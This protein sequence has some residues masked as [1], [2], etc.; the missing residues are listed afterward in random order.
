MGD[1]TEDKEKPQAAETSGGGAEVSAGDESAS[2]GGGAPTTMGKMVIPDLTP[3]TIGQND[4]VKAMI[5]VS[6]EASKALQ[7]IVASQRQ[8]LEAAL[9]NMQVSVQESSGNAA[10][11]SG[12]IPTIEVPIQ[13][14]KITIDNFCTSAETL[15]ASTTKN[16]DTLSETVNKSLTTIEEVATKF[17]GG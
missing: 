14:L 3:M 2:A 15:S 13:N 5:K 10:I 12:K 8:A 4:N 16:F 9:K 7:S 17:S 1:G 11:P 6:Q